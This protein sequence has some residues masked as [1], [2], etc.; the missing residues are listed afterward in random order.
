MQFLQNLEKIKKTKL[1]LNKKLNSLNVG[2]I[3]VSQ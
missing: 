1:Y 3:I 2:L